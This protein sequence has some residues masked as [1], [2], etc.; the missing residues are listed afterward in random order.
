MV[1]PGGWQKILSGKGESIT[2]FRGYAFFSLSQAIFAA[3]YFRRGY[4][5]V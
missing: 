4:G 2:A 1:R 3:T 5:K